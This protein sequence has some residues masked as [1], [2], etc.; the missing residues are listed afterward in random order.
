[1]LPE[2]LPTA[3]KCTLMLRSSLMGGKV[4]LQTRGGREVLFT[5]W[6][7]ANMVPN[8]RMCGFEMMAQMR[9]A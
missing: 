6:P 8:I 4:T 2:G 7:S 5:S 3:R 9:F 1:M